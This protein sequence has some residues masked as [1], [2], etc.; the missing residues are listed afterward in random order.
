LN[1]L[2][3][4]LRAMLEGVPTLP[5]CEVCGPRRAAVDLPG[6]GT[7]EVRV[8]CPHQEA[9]FVQRRADEARREARQVWAQT[10]G[11]QL[12]AREGAGVRL[13]DLRDVAGQREGR[14]V[15]ERY[16]ATFAARR[17]DGTGLV[18]TGPVGTGKTAVLAAL[19]N[20]VEAG[21]WT[22]AW[23]S[24]PELPRRLRDFDKAP[25]YL[26]ALRA[27][28][29]LVI[30]EFG[31]ERATEFT[32]VEIFDL[33]DHRYRAK[34]PLLLTTNLSSAELADHYTRCLTQGRDRLPPHEAE[35][36]VHRVLSRIRERC[37]PVRFTGPDLRQALKATWLTTEDTP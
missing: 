28:D 31:L 15:A 22:V 34:A 7:V 17:V 26:A 10:H 37:L 25:A 14:R 6:M 4:A 29:V 30:D 8:P 27:A 36:M 11:E 33:I 23:C 18:F 12:P 35:L 3:L 32:S 5:V 20:E 16:L 13:A 24:A 9:E 21:D 2:S 1:A 19:V